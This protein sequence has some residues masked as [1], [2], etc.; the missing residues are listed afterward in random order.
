MT[1]D[2]KDQESKDN[3][4]SVTVKLNFRIPPGMRSVFAHH[5]FVQEDSSEI[6][7]SFFEVV[8]PII[9]PDKYEEY[10]KVM[11]QTG[12]NADCVARI[13][14][15]RNNLPGFAKAMMQVAE[16]IMAEFT[17]EEKNADDRTDD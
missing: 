12:V 15:A 17:E 13:K 11:Q 16:Q 1:E 9:P 6:T 5:L 3:V 14:V 10:L 7:L 4:P 8:T 2:N